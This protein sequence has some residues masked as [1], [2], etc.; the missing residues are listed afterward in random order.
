MN[1]QDDLSDPVIIAEGLT[2][3]SFG[4]VLHCYDEI[5][6]TNTLALRLA[7]ER[8]PEGTL[9]L[10]ERQTSGR[11]RLG[12]RWESSFGV[13]IW[14][15][16]ILRPDI[17]QT[18]QW[19]VT[20]TA[21]VGTAR[22]IRR[23]T[24]LDARLKWPNDILIDGKKTCGILTEVR[25]VRGRIIAAIVGIGVN[26]NHVV[27]DFPEELRQTATSLRIA[28]GGQQVRR[29][30]LLQG[31]LIEIEHEY[32]RLRRFGGKEFLNRWRASSCTFGTAVTV[33]NGESVVR[34]RAIDL[35]EDG[36]LVIEME[37]GVRRTVYSGDIVES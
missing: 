24:G 6:S 18:L 31:M 7:D 14:C 33:R 23:E 10:A 22:A 5:D 26:V 25:A 19:Q 35:L 28:L 3:S 15:S 34:G 37:N 2:T 20:A 12:R 8:S 4:R 9:V 30:R 27:E 17:P 11:G 32:G 36:G 29:I 13:G 16:L 21:A 1:S